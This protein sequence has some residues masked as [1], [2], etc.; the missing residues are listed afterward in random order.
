[1]TSTGETPL[2]NVTAMVTGYEDIED[3]PEEE[4]ATV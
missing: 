3:A 4:P 2:S 1:M